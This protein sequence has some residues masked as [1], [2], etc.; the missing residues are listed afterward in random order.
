M[1][2]PDSLP[3]MGAGVEDNPVA[4]A[5]HALGHRHLVGVGDQ[6]GQQAVADRGQLSQVGVVSAR[7]HEYVYGSLRIDIAEG[8]C[9]VIS[10]HYG[11]GYLVSGNG[12]EQAVR[13]AGDLNVWRVW[14][15][16]D[17]YGCTTAN[18]RCTTPLV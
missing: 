2:M 11:R 9:P 8:D 7:D 10:G 6:F 1:D 15:A 14:N 17:I 4:V 16:A 13:H 12:A 18:P 5:G 3:A